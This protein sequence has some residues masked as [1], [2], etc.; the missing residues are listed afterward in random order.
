MKVRAVTG[1]YRDAHQFH[2]VVGKDQVLR[3][4]IT[5]HVCVWRV[6][7]PKGRSVRRGFPLYFDTQC[8]VLHLTYSA[9]G[10]YRHKSCGRREAVLALPDVQSR[11]PTF[12]TAFAASTT[13]NPITS[14]VSSSG[15]HRALPPA[16]PPPPPSPPASA[17]ARQM[18]C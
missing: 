3:T 10:R 2:V 9:V 11:L 12:P 1:W 15:H 6:E 14:C 7:A 16:S 13:T 18:P 17:S 5:V 8:A 4:V